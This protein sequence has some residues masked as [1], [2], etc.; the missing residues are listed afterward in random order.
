MADCKITNQAAYDGLKERAEQPLIKQL[1]EC[2]EGSRCV[3]FEYRWNNAFYNNAIRGEYKKLCGHT[4]ASCSSVDEF[5]C[6]ALLSA[7]NAYFGKDE[8]GL[9]AAECRMLMDFPYSHTIYRPSYRSKHAGDYADQF[10]TVLVNSIFY[11]CCGFGR[12]HTKSVNRIALDLRRGDGDIYAAVTEAITGD[13]TEETFSRTII[14]AVVKSG[15]PKALE[16]LG[17][18]LLAAK[19]QEGL[20]QA[21]LETC[22]S[23]TI[24][25]HVYFIKLILDNG[26]CRFSSVIRA[27]DTWCGLSFGDQKQKTVEKMMTLSTEYLKY[28][29]AAR[30]ALKSPDT[31]EIYMGLWAISCRDVH[32]AGDISVKLLS[33]AEKYRRLV[34]WYFITHTNNDNFRH[35]VAVQFLS[36]REPEEL[37]WAALNIKINREIYSYLSDYN[38]EYDEKVEKDATE[39]EYP[40]GHYPCDLADR[41][42]LFDKAAEAA[43]FIGKKSSVFKPSVFPWYEAQLS[44]DNLLGLMIGLA[45]YDRN[46]ELTLRIAKYLPITDS[47]NRLRYYGKLLNPKKPRHREL[48]LE[49]LSDKSPYVKTMILKRLLFYPLSA[50]DISALEK[51][52]T[53]ANANLRKA[54]IT[55]LEKQESGLI[56]PAIGRLLDG[57][58]SAQVLAGTELIEIFGKKEPRIIAAFES[59]VSALRAGGGLG[60]DFEILARRVYPDKKAPAELTPENGFGLFN[61]NS[62][63]LNANHWAKKRPDVKQLTNAALQTLIVPDA[64]EAIDFYSRLLDVLARN[65]DYEYEAFSYGGGRETTLLGAGIERLATFD[66]QNPKGIYDYPLADEW[67][68]AAGS[69]ADA[70][71]KFAAVL[72]IWTYDYQYKTY[73]SWFSDIFKGYPIYMPANPVAQKVTDIFNSFDVRA[74]PCNMIIK[75]LI[76]TSGANLFDFAMTAYVNLVNKVPADRFNDVISEGSSRYYYCGEKVLEAVYLQYWQ[77]LAHEHI[78][79]DEQFISYFSEMWYEYLASGKEQYYGLG[80]EDIIRAHSLG[81]ITDEIVYYYLLMY[82]K[83]KRSNNHPFHILTGNTWAKKI[84][85][86]YP[87]AKALSDKALDTVLSVESKRG[88]LETPLTY[89]AGAI[90]RFNGGITHFVTLLAAIG[91]GGFSRAAISE[92][93]SVS[94]KKDSLSHL[95]RRCLPLQTDTAQALRDALH[96]AKIPEKRALM[97]A[98]FAP[99]W[100][101]LLEQAL[102]IPGLKCAVWFFNA[103]INEHFSAE[104]E[105]EVA[106][107]S[108][109]TPQR[110]NDGAFDKDWFFE[111]YDT[112]GE[113]RFIE[114]YKNAKLTTD[115]NI[116]HRRSQL[117]TEA[118]LGR[119]DKAET[120]SEIKDKRN[121]EKLRAYALIPLDANDR[122]DALQ[123][124]EFISQF[125]KE[126]RQFGSLRQASDGRAVTAALDNLAITTG[127]GDADRMAWALEGQKIE[128]LRPMMQPHTIGETTVRLVILPDGSPEVEAEKKGRVLKSVPKELNKDEYVTDLKAA[129]KAL[130]DQKS[131][132]RLKLEM[133]MVSRA[134]FKPEEIAGLLQN[135]VLSGM[136]ADIVFLS[137]DILGFPALSEGKVTLK[138]FDGMFCATPADLIIAHPYDFMRNKCWGN[139]QRHLFKN[140]IK[141]PFKQVFREYYPITEDE[142]Q[143]A[144]VS[145]RYEGYQVQ[146]KKTVALLKTRGWTVDYEE[147]LQRVWHRENLIAR[148]Y[149]MAD[150]FSPSDIEAPTL[151]TVQFYRR[152]NWE[153]VPFEQVPPV[154][155]SETMR[156]IDLAVSVAYVGG[157]D[158]EASHSTVEMRLAIAREL[159]GLLSVKNVSFKTAH[160]IIGGAF[161]EYSVHLGSGIIHKLNAGMIAV[162]PVHSQHRGRVFLPFADDDPKTAEIM[163]K[164]LMFAEDKKIKDPGIL[165][166]IR[167]L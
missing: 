125:K 158:P 37:A 144:N 121:Q 1:W 163:S 137:D 34:G 49:G 104:K 43:E 139:Y 155:F 141:Q 18:L 64:R 72:S 111:A 31:T 48:F 76:F 123:R 30:E 131:R 114:L 122:S 2:F 164:I 77:Q 57:G 130:K 15:S 165:N 63:L 100:A 96:K 54:A 138:S 68:A 127:Y 109:I 22:D 3:S 5:L 117:Y 58:N 95:L 92:Y 99:Q 41:V 153:R 88:E 12:L 115:S 110:F 118:V 4:A 154:I 157:V 119:M 112:L 106:I 21:V 74:R 8:T 24:D 143:A 120:L 65:R 124:Y 35:S 47:E 102:Q 93:K 69:F 9:I 70:P 149:A 81:L 62:E 140:Q 23:G 145:I 134:A 52:L 71:E 55:L 162:L 7:L 75:A 14:S 94:T 159:L 160:A 56:A 27:F 59:K 11:Q 135:P 85:D 90:H 87:A 98:L 36:V 89:A 38:Q 53:T 101:G 148:M 46:D 83:N 33:S 113:K 146:P 108:S 40:A 166:Q 150:W 32:T 28:E 13:T 152:D 161:G 142:K 103:H 61:P 6:P 51:S 19:L 82:P 29:N 44:A 17:G 147:G 50:D 39:K 136:A 133:A 129:A 84:F 26:L 126:S 128:Q 10:F 107:F 97:A 66:R 86:K 151:E 167:G 91:N 116:A 16:L 60:E 20:R 67:L 45:A 73:L 42:S 132:A 25:S 105:T 80:D 78:T 156:D 79:N